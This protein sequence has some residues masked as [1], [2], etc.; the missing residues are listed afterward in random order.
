M[1][2]NKS[3]GI[4]GGTFDPIHHGHLIVAERAREEFFLDKIILVPSALPPHKK[5]EQVL[6]SKHR[7]KMVELAIQNNS[8]IELSDIE[9]QREGYSYTIDT[10]QQFRNNYDCDIY[11]I[12]GVDALMLIDTWKDYNKLLDICHFIVVTRP[13][14]ELNKEAECFTEIS[15]DNWKK[16]HI[17]NIP[18]MDISSSEIRKR[19]GKGNTIKYLL[20]ETVEEYICKNSLYLIEEETS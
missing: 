19:I 11:F 2:N 7:L 17:I 13:G 15:E 1:K 12:L 4:L 16:I 5:V 3:I 10:I 9:M 14:Y 20:P 6:D 18:A 8:K